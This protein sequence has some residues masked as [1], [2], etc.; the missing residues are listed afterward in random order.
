MYLIISDTISQHREYHTYHPNDYGGMVHTLGG[1]RYL[2]SDW[3]RLD[4]A[5]HIQPTADGHL[6][7]GIFVL[8][9]SFSSH[10]AI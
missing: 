5:H 6:R 3:R 1:G 8:N 9:D 10:S 7:P 4:N 2:F